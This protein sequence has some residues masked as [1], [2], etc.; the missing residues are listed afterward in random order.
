MT[1]YVYHPSGNLLLRPQC[2]YAVMAHLGMQI[3]Q[4]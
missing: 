4:P 2:N 3:S 1:A